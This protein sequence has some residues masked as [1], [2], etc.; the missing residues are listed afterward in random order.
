[1]QVLLGKVGVHS[2][3]VIITP[4]QPTKGTLVENGEGGLN[5]SSSF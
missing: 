3:W 5:V 4:L 1:M 2:Q